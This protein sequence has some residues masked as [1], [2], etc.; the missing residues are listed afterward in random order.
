[1][2][3]D[4]FIEYLDK[5]KSINMKRSN[6]STYI[7]AESF[8]RHL[9]DL[10]FWSLLMCAHERIYVLIDPNFLSW[11]FGYLSQK[12]IEISKLLASLSPAKAIQTD[13]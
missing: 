8:W 3:L 12:I 5:V 1:M 7:K 2:Y 4:T 11:S 6:I 13:T 9:L 10:V